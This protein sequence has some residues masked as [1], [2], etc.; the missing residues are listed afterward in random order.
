MNLVTCEIFL[1]SRYRIGDENRKLSNLDS[2][3]S[4]PASKVWLVSILLRR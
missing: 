1:E 2:I 3:K 4:E